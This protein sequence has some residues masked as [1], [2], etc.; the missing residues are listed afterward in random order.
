MKLDPRQVARYMAGLVLGVASGLLLVYLLLLSA[1]NFRWNPDAQYIGAWID[2]KSDLANAMATPKVIF[3]GGSNVQYGIR[4][5]VFASELGIPAINFGLHGA[6]PLDYLIACVQKIAKP[7]DVVVFI[8]EY[9]YF[10]KDSAEINPVAMR[11]LASDDQAFLRSRGT[12]ELLLTVPPSILWARFFHYPLH[13]QAEVDQKTKD[14]LTTFNSHGDREWTESQRR[15]EREW[16]RLRN[17]KPTD[18]ASAGD[19][20]KT[21]HFPEK[22]LIDFQKW[23]QNH[24]VRL[25]ACYPNTVEFPEYSSAASC[26]FLSRLAQFYRDHE[27]P[28]PDTPQSG[29]LPQE[30]FFDSV[31]HPHQEASV[32][33]SHRLLET[34]K[35][36]LNF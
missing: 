12:R 19:P 27:I 4:A 33:R 1:Q 25:I 13:V 6:L 22:S 28:N 14:H 24:Q 34:L 31:Y 9:E 35:P 36:F 16:T 2:R 7:G 21:L 30:D 15:T 20:E 11:Y 3:A 23:C 18:L 10:F 26:A 17:I 32:A 29:F 8:P 5:G